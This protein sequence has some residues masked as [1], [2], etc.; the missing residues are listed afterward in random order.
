[1]EGKE[2]ILMPRPGFV[3]EVDGSTPPL[4]YSNG[5]GF[6]LERLPAD[7]SR[8][9]YPPEP[10]APL[11]DPDAAVRHALLH[12]LDSEPLPELLHAGMKLTIAF[13]DVSLPLPPMRR[14]DNRQRVIEAVLDM[15]AAAGVDD[16]HLIA[17]LALHRRMTEEELRHAVGD[18]VYD[19]FA[20]TGRIYNH[21]AEDPDGMAEIGTTEHGELVEINRRAAESDLLVYV[22]VN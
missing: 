17:A 3:L 18:R 19:A 22:N 7:R 21:D 14:P 9:I 13:D 2:P 12:P 10:I 20:P 6:R 15:A 4:L 8:V 5:E 11:R 16:I 1:R